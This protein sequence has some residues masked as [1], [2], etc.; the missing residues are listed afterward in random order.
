MR[1]EPITDAELEA[2]MHGTLDALRRIERACA[3]LIS[4]ADVEIEKEQIV[5]TAE[6]EMRK[7][8]ELLKRLDAAA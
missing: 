7:I 4:G 8:D 1:T 3:G 2:A 5:P 6:R